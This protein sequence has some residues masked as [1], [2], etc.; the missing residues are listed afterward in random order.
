MIGDANKLA[1]GLITLAIV[2]VIVG[3][4]GG[5][6]LVQLFGSALSWSAG[7]FSQLTGGGK[8]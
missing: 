8:K 4:N 2:A 3:G 7:L 6:A 1:V 5:R